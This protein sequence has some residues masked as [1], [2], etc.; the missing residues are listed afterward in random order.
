MILFLDVDGVCHPQ[1]W[2]AAGVQELVFLPRIESVLRE[3]PKTQI[4]ICSD[5]RVRKPWSE[6]LSIFAPDVPAMVTGATP[7]I[8]SEDRWPAKHR[9]R[10][11]M[12]Y[13]SD[14]GMKDASWVALDDV[15]ANW[16][17]GD[18][19]VIVAKDG[20]Y[21]SEEC[22]LRHILNGW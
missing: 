4:V 5:W 14:N 11:A 10:E 1:E 21:D 17:I 18:P 13:L 7:V 12:K 20:F 19:Q 16:V 15:A 8:P 9:Y 6:V 3:F 2:R 22:A